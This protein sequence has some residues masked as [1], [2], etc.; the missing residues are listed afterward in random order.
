MSS[1]GR[2]GFL[3]GLLVSGAAVISIADRIG[4]ESVQALG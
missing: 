4:Q 3:G 2:R 1:F